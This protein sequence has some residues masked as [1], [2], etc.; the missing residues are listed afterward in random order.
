MLR[1][2]IAQSTIMTA[3]AAALWTSPAAAETYYAHPELSLEGVV[4]RQA[5]VLVDRAQ[6]DVAHMYAGASA[7]TE[8]AATVAAVR[9]AFQSAQPESDETL[10]AWLTFTARRPAP[11]G[12]PDPSH[13]PLDRALGEAH[14]WLRARAQVQR[15]V[16]APQAPLM[17]TPLA[18]DWK[19][20]AEAF[21]SGDAAALPAAMPDATKALLGAWR[22]AARSRLSDALMPDDKSCAQLVADLLDIVHPYADPT[23]DTHLEAL[24]PALLERDEREPFLQEGLEKLA[25]TERLNPNVDLVSA[26]REVLPGWSTLRILRLLGALSHNHSIE[27]VLLERA[28]IAGDAEREAVESALRRVT[29]IN[30][31]Y[32]LLNAYNAGAV[33]RPY[34]Q[35]G[36]ALVSCELVSRGHSMLVTQLAGGMLGE[37]YEAATAGRGELD[38]NDVARHREGTR[39][40]LKIC[41]VGGSNS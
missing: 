10:E 4:Q 30:H 3:L 22:L 33:E 41:S 11:R 36:A 39:Y 28:L 34:H 18:P 25:A 21:C 35:Y 37:L 7:E 27:L 6:R 5:A 8:R 32:H 23:R 26:V 38:S 16:G 14:R 29:R 12:E 19:K 1:F 2:S 31:A 15:L 13:L 40:G 20:R 17:Q 9:R 24:S